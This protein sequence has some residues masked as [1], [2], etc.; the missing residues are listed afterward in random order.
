M[1]LLTSGDFP[2]F[3]HIE[4]HWQ[5]GFYQGVLNL[6][7]EPTLHSVADDGKARLPGQLTGQVRALQ[8]FCGGGLA[9]KM[10]VVYNA[11]DLLAAFGLDALHV[12]QGPVYIP[13][14]RPVGI[15]DV[16]KVKFLPL[17]LGGKASQ[18]PGADG[19]AAD[20]QDAG[21]APVLK[22]GQNCRVDGGNVRYAAAGGDDD[23]DAGGLQPLGLLIG[24]EIGIDNVQIGQD[25]FFALRCQPESQ[26]YGVL[27]FSAAVRN[28]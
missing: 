1:F 12:G 10:G 19:V 8:D 2:G 28:R 16:Q 11:C 24:A 22:H 13:G 23:P 3:F 18:N 25:G 27:G 26:V 17:N 5:N 21:P 4:I 20:V 15:E 9:T 6:R 14:L 7:H